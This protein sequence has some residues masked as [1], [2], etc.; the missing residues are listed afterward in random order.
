MPGEQS[1]TNKDFTD[2]NDLHTKSQGG[3]K[4]VRQIV[5]AAVD[6]NRPKLIDGVKTDDIKILA[7]KTEAVKETQEGKQKIEAKPVQVKSENEQPKR[8]KSR[9]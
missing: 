5:M 9:V 3:I 6:E 1:P 4:A 7:A 8:G 2:F